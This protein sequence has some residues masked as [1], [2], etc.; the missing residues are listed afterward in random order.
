MNTQTRDQE[1]APSGIK[2]DTIHDG[3]LEH[4]V[5]NYL[6]EH[7]DISPT[8]LTDTSIALDTA[9]TNVSVYH[10]GK[11]NLGGM[12]LV[13][14]QDITSGSIIGGTEPVW[15]VQKMLDE[16]ERERCKF[17]HLLTQRRDQSLRDRMTQII[18]RIE[19]AS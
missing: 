1:P 13:V 15:R 5:R 19:N 4:F 18:E 10:L 12:L 2:I 3:N 9:T 17:E 6:D 16:A 7:H 8:K 11:N 14:K